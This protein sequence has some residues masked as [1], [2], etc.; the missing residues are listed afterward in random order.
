MWQPQPQSPH[1]ERSVLRGLGASTQQATPCIFIPWP[2]PH[3]PWTLDCYPISPDGNGGSEAV[4]CP[5]CPPEWMWNGGSALGSGPGLRSPQLSYYLQGHHPPH[6][7]LLFLKLF[8][9]KNKTQ[10]TVLILVY[11]GCTSCIIHRDLLQLER[12][13]GPRLGWQGHMRAF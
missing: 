10:K 3:G 2:N 4:S 5:R 13:P 9:L 1:L 8:F 6:G 7:P 11:V 12:G